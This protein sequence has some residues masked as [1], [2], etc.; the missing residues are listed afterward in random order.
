MIAIIL[1]LTITNFVK[2]IV[3]NKDKIKLNKALSEY[4]SIDIAHE[5][6]S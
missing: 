5:I 3:E 2:Y 4:V 1:S 6:L